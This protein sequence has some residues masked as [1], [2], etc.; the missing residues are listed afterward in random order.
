M[1]AGG[2][3]G[4]GVTAEP[5]PQVAEH[6]LVGPPLMIGGPTSTSWREHTLARIAELRSLADWVESKLNPD[7]PAELRSLAMIR[8]HLDAAKE[9]AEGSLATWPQRLKSALGG[10]MIERAGS[11]LDAAEGELLRI[12]PDEYVCGQMSNLLAHVRGHLAADDPRRQVVE[13]ISAR[14]PGATLQPIEREALVT[15]V[16]IGSL[17][18]RREIGRVRSFRNVLLVTAAVLSLVAGG[19]VV[20]G[21]LH[22][23]VMPLCFAPGKEVVCPTSV[24]SVAGGAPTPADAA[25]LSAGEVDPVI[26]STASSWDF[27]VVALVGLIAAAVAAAAA[28]RTIKGTTTPYS[29][30]IAL[31][32]LKLPT[33]VLTAILGLLLMRGEF[34]PGLT[35][36]DSPA[37]IIAWAIVLGYA[38]QILTGMVDRRAQGVLDDVGGG[39]NRPASDATAAMP[40]PATS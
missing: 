23:N 3:N 28:L 31:A 14:R 6:D 18:A 1:R 33:G 13:K 12:A 35:A 8:A 26:R 7:E 4:A 9:A 16:R 38:Q 15:A 24:A 32:I 10:A 30:P 5:P 37:Q 19:M 21:T 2:R 17:E 11:N 22:P 29:L 36:L 39:G 27:L 25:T 34:V 40:A 20:V